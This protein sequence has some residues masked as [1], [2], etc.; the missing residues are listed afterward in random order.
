MLIE[1]EG[2][3]VDKDLESRRIQLQNLESLHNNKVDELKSVCSLAEQER[4]EQQ[5]REREL[6]QEKHCTEEDR[7][8]R[9]I[10]KLNEELQNVLT[11]FE[12]ISSLTPAQKSTTKVAPVK[13]ELTELEHE[14]Q[15]CGCGKVCCPPNKIYQCPEGDL[16]CESC[17]GPADS[18]LKN[19]PSCGVELAGLISRNK[20][21]ENIAK[22]YFMDK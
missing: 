14:L 15:C 11:P 2:G 19:C 17:R 6:L 4:I 5:V 1:V 7:I 9:E 8:K 3:Q 18:R 10:S 22:K 13:P 21:L 16:I 12:L 20:V